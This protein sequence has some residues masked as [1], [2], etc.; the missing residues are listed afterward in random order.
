MSAPKVAQVSIKL[1]YY[2][3]PSCTS[4]TDA[5]RRYSCLQ[6]QC[7]KLTNPGIVATQLLSINHGYDLM[8]NRDTGHTG[9]TGTGKIRGKTL[10]SEK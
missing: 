4:L 6:Y 5:I 10:A 9:H 2:A 8:L 7:N 3:I 1:R